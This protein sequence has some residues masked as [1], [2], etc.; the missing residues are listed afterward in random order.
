M[1]EDMTKQY[2]YNK[3][4][5]NAEKMLEVIEKDPQSNWINSIEKLVPTF[6]ALG[7]ASV[8]IGVAINSLKGVNK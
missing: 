4:R 8:G 7:I 5:E 3:A 2:D 1:E 6:Y